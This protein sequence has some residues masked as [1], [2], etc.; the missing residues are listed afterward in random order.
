MKKVKRSVVARDLGG[1]G[2]NTKS[3]EDFKGS[4][5]TLQ[6]TVIIMLKPK[7]CTHKR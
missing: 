1:R 2:K 6:D 5:E 7:A 3:T 4:E